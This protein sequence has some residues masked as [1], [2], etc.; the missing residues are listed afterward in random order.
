M[1]FAIMIFPIYILAHYL[2]KCICKNHERFKC[3]KNFIK[4]KNFLMIYI[5]F[6][7]EGCIELGLTGSVSIIMLNSDRVSSLSEFLSTALAIFFCISLAIAPIY[8][9]FAG[10]QLYRASKRRDKKVIERLKPIFDGK[11]F[12]DK[13][14][15]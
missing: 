5:I 8:T 12:N 13:L 14:A 1:F 2:A 6:M 10:C 7:L 15:I 4:P 9:F 11:R 3:M